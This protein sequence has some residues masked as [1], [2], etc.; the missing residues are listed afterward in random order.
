MSGHRPNCGKCLACVGKAIA[1]I[2]RESELT[3]NEGGVVMMDLLAREATLQ[4]VDERV[5][6]RGLAIVLAQCMTSAQGTKEVIDG[7]KKGGPASDREF[8]NLVNG[9][10]RPQ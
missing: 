3:L 6:V 1:A 8:V 5:F 4:K 9:P 10:E 2:L 7:I